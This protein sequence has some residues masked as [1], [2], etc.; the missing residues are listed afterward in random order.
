ML[1]NENKPFS[2]LLIDGIFLTCIFEFSDFV[3]TMI[4]KCKRKNSTKEEEEENEP[5]KSSDDELAMWISGICFIFILLLFC[6]GKL[7]K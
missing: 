3:A 4:R 6:L 7:L 5:A 1:L 2:Y